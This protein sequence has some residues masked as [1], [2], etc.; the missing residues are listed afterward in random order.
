MFAISMFYI[1]TLAMVYTVSNIYVYAYCYG[2][3][4][5]FCTVHCRVMFSEPTGTENWLLAVSDTKV[6]YTICSHMPVYVENFSIF[7]R[8]FSKLEKGPMGREGKRGKKC[9]VAVLY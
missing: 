5:I 4:C 7:R 6:Y 9:I 8:G 1:N 3:P 2:Y